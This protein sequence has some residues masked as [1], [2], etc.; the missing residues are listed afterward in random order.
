MMA[1]KTG[2]PINGRIT[3][4]WT[5]MP[6]TS[7]NSDRDRYGLPPWQADTVHQPI[8]EE[9][10]QHRHFALGEIRDVGDVE[11]DDDRDADHRIETA[12][13]EPSNNQIS[14]HDK[15]VP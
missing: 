7:P 6:C 14:D 9:R 12:G 5:T 15:V 11:H 10:R 3:T 2:P 4:C 13:R 1:D 8:G